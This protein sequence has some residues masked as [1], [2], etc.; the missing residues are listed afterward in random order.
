MS[1]CVFMKRERES[2]CPPLLFCVCVRERENEVEREVCNSE[3]EGGG[4]RGAE[5]KRGERVCACW[6]VGPLVRE[7]EREN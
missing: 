4:R 5:R 1:A 6:S 3:G 2:I 7:G